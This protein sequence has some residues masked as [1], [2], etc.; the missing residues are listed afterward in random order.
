[1]YVRRL[2][3]S[4]LILAA[5]F[6]AFASPASAYPDPEH[7]CELAR[8]L[9]KETLKYVEGGR[10]FDYD[11]RHIFG[12][13][14]DADLARSAAKVYGHVDGEILSGM[15]GSDSWHID[16][17]TYIPSKKTGEMTCDV[18]IDYHGD[19]SGKMQARVRILQKSDSGAMKISDILY[20]S[21]SGLMNMGK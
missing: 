13:Y 17:L 16:A 19:L 1:M 8:V 9:Y 21:G 6:I 18:L 15:D 3:V 2:S 12:T 10:V 14:F 5:T 4:G 20:G 7:K 11:A